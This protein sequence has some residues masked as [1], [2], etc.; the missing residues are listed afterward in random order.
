MNLP[1]MFVSPTS[2]GRAMQL[3][4]SALTGCSLIWTELS[5]KVSYYT[6]CL[7][8][9]GRDSLPADRTCMFAVAAFWVC[10]PVHTS[11]ILPKVTCG[12]GGKTRINCLLGNYNY[13]STSLRWNDWHTAMHVHH[14]DF[15]FY[16]WGHHFSI[17][18]GACLPSPWQVT[19]NVFSQETSII[20]H[21]SYF[22]F[23]MREGRVF[24][25][26]SVPG[27]GA[28]SSPH[29]GLGKF[30]PC[31]KLPCQNPYSEDN[32]APT[33][34]FCQACLPRSESPLYF[35]C[36][37]I[38][39]Y[40]GSS[41]TGLS[42]QTLDNLVTT[43]LGLFCAKQTIQSFYVQDA[44]HLVSPCS[45]PGHGPPDLQRL[46]PGCRLIGP[47]HVEDTV[48]GHEYHPQCLPCPLSA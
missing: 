40:P 31:P 45:G 25:F 42:P 26:P 44:D 24:S 22:R 9:A 23:S 43:L 5:F 10:F 32:N 13:S 18:G 6:I 41:G 7:G 36:L 39:H 14:P 17:T 48:S 21:L 11:Q 47:L 27:L 29:I 16:H 37:S 3:P 2:Q 12:G 35:P 1:E 15:D 20:L 34:V 30:L 38:E 46:P 4:W 8:S 19:A 28:K 33:W